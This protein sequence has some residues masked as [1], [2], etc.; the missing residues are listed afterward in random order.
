MA[1]DATNATYHVPQPL[2]RTLCYEVHL[3]F[4]CA[5]SSG[6]DSGSTRVKRVPA[7][8][9]VELLSDFGPVNRAC[10]L[11]VVEICKTCEWGMV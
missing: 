5:C 6:K 1:T 10:V 4:A 7:P 8:A 11:S 9:S 2:R 3:R